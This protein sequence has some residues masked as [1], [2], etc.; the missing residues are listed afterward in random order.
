MGSRAVLEAATYHSAAES[1]RYQR[2]MANLPRLAND[3]AATEKRARLSA[4]TFDALF[5][6]GWLD[7]VSPRSSVPSCGQWPTLLETSR[8][9]ARACASTGWMIALVG[10]HGSIVRRLPPEHRQHLYACGPRQL[11]AS[12]SASDGSRFTWTPD[13]IRVDGRWR[14]SSGIQD[15]T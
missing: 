1:E 2:F 15:A 4:D 5:S 8:I 14:F 9:A 11:F 6:G 10:G 13:G 12:A 7:L 3:A